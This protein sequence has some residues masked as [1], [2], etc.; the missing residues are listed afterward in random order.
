MLDNNTNSIYFEPGICNLSE[1]TAIRTRFGIYWYDRIDEL[2]GILFK[3]ME[4]VI[5][6]ADHQVYNTDLKP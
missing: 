4:F 5:I 2:R 1:F 3:L 6:L